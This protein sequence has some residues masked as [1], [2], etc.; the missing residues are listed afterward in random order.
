VAAVAAPSQFVLNRHR[1]LGF[2]GRAKTAI[3]P[4][5]LPV[6]QACGVPAPAPPVRFLYLGQLRAHKGIRVMLDAFAQLDSG[7]VSLAI[8]GAGELESECATA[9]A[10]DRRIRFH[11]V[12]RG[13]DKNRLLAASHVLLYPSIWWEVLGLSILEAL[14]AGLPAIGSRIGGIPE[15]VDDGATGWLVPPGDSK[16]LAGRMR[17]LVADPSLVGRMSLRCRERARQ[18]T[19]ERTVG[20]LL[21]VYEIARGG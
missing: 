20:A 15:I 2:F 17:S 21:D 12:V 18:F 11:G 14:G 7:D 19:V 3:V 10:R 13:D 4:W 8:A 9:A 6:P 1:E 5:G 16:A